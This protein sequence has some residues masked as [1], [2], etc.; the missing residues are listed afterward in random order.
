M[1]SKSLGSPRKHLPEQ[2]Y[3]L[4]LPSMLLVDESKHVGY[5]NFV[6]K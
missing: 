3:Y 4:D 1:Q 6:D 5:Y 2:N